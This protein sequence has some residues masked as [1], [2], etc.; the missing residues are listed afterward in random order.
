M[1]RRC[2]L[3]I[4]KKILQS[5]KENKE[6]SLGKIERKTNAN[7][8]TIVNHIKELE[9]L[10]IVEITKHKKNK[11]TGR[12]YTTVRLTEYGKKLI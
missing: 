4:K 7:N 12:P 11:L 1:K 3:D 10:G 6:L 5:L 9:F 8:L 2:G